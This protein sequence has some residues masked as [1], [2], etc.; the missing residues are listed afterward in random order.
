MNALSITNAV[1]MCMLF[2]AAFILFGASAGLLVPGAALLLAL[3]G[4]RTA[5]F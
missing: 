2:A 5:Q 4:V 1:L 3:G